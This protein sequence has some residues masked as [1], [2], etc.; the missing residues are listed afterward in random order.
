ME[1]KQR[2]DLGKAVQSESKDEL[3]DQRR[4]SKP[5]LGG[6]G[7]VKSKDV[8]K[9]IVGNRESGVR[10]TWGKAVQSE[11]RDVNSDGYQIQ[12]GM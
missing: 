12:G 8:L 3:K 10:L 9:M 2:F 5:D 11:S 6:G 1:K 4:A 7:E